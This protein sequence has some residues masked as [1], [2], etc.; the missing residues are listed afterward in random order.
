MYYLPIKDRLALLLVSDIKHFFHYPRLRHKDTKHNQLYTDILDGSTWK[1]FESLLLPNE[2][3]LLGCN[4]VGMAQNCS[5]KGL[6]KSFWP[7]CVS[8][9]NFP[10]D[11]RSKL[12]IGL[13]VITLC[14]GSDAS[15]GL[16]ADE[17]LL[18]WNHGLVFDGVTW[19]V[20]L[21]N[22]VWDGKGFEQ[23]TKTQGSNSLAG[24]NACKLK[25][26]LPI[27]TRIYYFFTT[28]YYILL[29]FY[30]FFTYIYQKFQE[31]L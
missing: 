2:C 23:V 21:I 13:H 17:L 9:I 28:I 31:I 22:G 14:T 5:K 19:K 7:G 15:I 11:L 30:Y 8:I 4:D 10:I 16:L 27:F 26:N 25:G 29:V 12:H 24:C 1:S 3:A 6:G 18:L 20:A